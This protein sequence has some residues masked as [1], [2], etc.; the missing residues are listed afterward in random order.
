MPPQLSLQQLRARSRVECVDRP[1]QVAL[2]QDAVREDQRRDGDR[3]G[4]ARLPEHTARARIQSQT[5]GRGFES[6]P[7]RHPSR[8]RAR[9]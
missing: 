5:E 6:L 7:A 4:R 3:P 8:P 2:I 1:I 9:Y